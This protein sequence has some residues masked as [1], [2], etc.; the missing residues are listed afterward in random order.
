M[1]DANI[2]T[3]GLS[4]L[5]AQ[6]HL[7]PGMS[8]HIAQEH[9]YFEWGITFYEFQNK[10]GKKLLKPELDRQELLKAWG[11]II[12]T[13]VL[14]HLTARLPFDRLNREGV[15]LDT[16]ETK[17]LAVCCH[18]GRFD[19][20]LSFA[21]LADY[22]CIGRRAFNHMSPPTQWDAA[23]KR[24]VELGYITVSK[25]KIFYS[26]AVILADTGFEES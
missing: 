22:L 23:I 15:E 14:P 11:E 4:I 10:K 25:G 2:A 19:S 7:M 9:G 6:S 18:W 17:V 3:S 8:L 24:L 20:G 26:E 5:V 1:S 12:N 13:H 16:I 21:R